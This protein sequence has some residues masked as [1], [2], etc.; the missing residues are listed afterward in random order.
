MTPTPVGA[1]PHFQILL[2]WW[3][4][5]INRK[6]AFMAVFLFISGEAEPAASCWHPRAVPASAGSEWGH[7]PQTDPTDAEHRVGSGVQVPPLSSSQ[8]SYRLRRL[9]YALHEKAPRAHFAAPPSKTASHTGASGL[10]DNFVPALCGMRF[11]F[12][13]CLFIFGKQSPRPLVGMPRRFPR[14]GEAMAPY[15]NSRREEK[16]FHCN[17][18]V[19]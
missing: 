8:A 10:V 13:G 14:S 15:A 1:E 12:W 2:K 3:S 6:A 11:C 7:P 9:F 16:D 4:F 18:G 5:S 17:F 19:C